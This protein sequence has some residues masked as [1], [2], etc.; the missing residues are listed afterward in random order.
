MESELKSR[1]LEVKE[2]L[3]E[4]LITE[5]E[6]HYKKN[7][8]LGIPHSMMGP[9]NNENLKK[10]RELGEGRL[11]TMMKD[12]LTDYGVGK[13][14]LMKMYHGGAPYHLGDY[15]INYEILGNHGKKIFIKAE[16]EQFIDIGESEWSQLEGKIKVVSAKVYA[17]INLETIDMVFKEEGI[18]EPICDGS[19][20]YYF[21]YSMINSSYNPNLNDGDICS[22]YYE[23][24]HVW[25]FGDGF[26]V[27]SSNG[28]GS[29]DL[30]G[31]IPLSNK[32][33]G[34]DPY[35][36]S[37]I[38]KSDEL[39]GSGIPFV[40]NCNNQC[41][42][43]IQA[44]KKIKAINVS[45]PEGFEIFY[46]KAQKIT[47]KPV[48]DT[49]KEALSFTHS[50][51]NESGIINLT[52]IFHEQLKE[53]KEIGELI[54][55]YESYGSEDNP[56]SSSLKNCFQENFRHHEE[57]F[58]IEGIDWHT[59]SY[60]ARWGEIHTVVR[61]YVNGIWYCSNGF[62]PE[63]K[64]NF[65][66]LDLKFYKKKFNQDLGI[67]LYG[68]EIGGLQSNKES[69]K[70][71]SWLKIE[72]DNTQ[73]RYL[74]TQN[75]FWIR[76]KAKLFRD[77]E[78]IENHI[79]LQ[80]AFSVDQL[81]FF[82]PEMSRMSMH[83]ALGHS[84]GRGNQEYARAEIGADNIEVKVFTDKNIEKYLE[85]NPE[86]FGKE[87]IAALQDV[88]KRNPSEKDLESQLKRPP[89][90]DFKLFDHQIYDTLITNIIETPDRISIPLMYT[91]KCTSNFYLYS[92]KL[93]N[94]FQSICVWHRRKDQI[95]QLY[96][97]LS[98]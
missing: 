13:N 25:L 64:K 57:P 48:I 60:E 41:K 49:L 42:N 23:K 38:L 62:S 90:S 7:E 36:V 59:D 46:D 98:S 61:G 78:I 87:S 68:I 32:S 29:G 71:E 2:L 66:R 70:A 40:F 20:E 58:M 3:D 5:E 27:I 22:A 63:E 72:F 85:R 37:E 52:N 89:I 26:N 88:Y 19:D 34:Y 67:F 93:L 44:I 83:D 94:H 75:L 82:F 95:S 8:I 53:D 97:S 50:K 74:L 79:Q 91:Y 1:L 39:S 96:P 84:S 14:S 4:G 21:T 45:E 81:Q 30:F 55:N 92:Q 9:S 11:N 17:I 6:Y 16:L 31:L 65:G 47:Y 86:Y 76:Q 54:E 33:K 15:I 12:F 51:A 43:F 28:T 73:G 80:Y 24:P 18:K 56:F 35:Q 77:P 10:E 69:N